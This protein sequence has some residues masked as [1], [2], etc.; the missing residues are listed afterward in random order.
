MNVGPIRLYVHENGTLNVARD[1]EKGCFHLEPRGISEKL[2]WVKR[3]QGSS[4]EHRIAPGD[5]IRWIKAG[6]LE[7]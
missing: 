4:F 3:R 6:G 2:R 7:R 5:L 1:T